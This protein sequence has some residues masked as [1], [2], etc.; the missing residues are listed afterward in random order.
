MNV[1]EHPPDFAAWK[2]QTLKHFGHVFSI[3]DD[4]DRK[5]AIDRTLEFLEM[6]MDSFRRMITKAKATKRTPWTEKVIEKI[7]HAPTRTHYEN[8]IK[9]NL[10]MIAN[11]NP[12]RHGVPMP[13]AMIFAFNQRKYQ[14]MATALHLNQRQIQ[15][16]VAISAE[17]GFAKDGKKQGYAGFRAYT[18]GKWGDYY[19]KKTKTGGP[20]KLPFFTK[21]AWNAAMKL[22]KEKGGFS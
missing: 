22:K 9:V 11:V 14:T 10:W 8:L 19:N 3:H 6:Y 1:T 15:K 5:A 12:L 13:Q 4:E 20:R 7:S 16:Y 2:K 17:L 18:I 21:Q